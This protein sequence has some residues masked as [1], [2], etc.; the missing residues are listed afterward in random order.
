MLTPIR[1]KTS[2]ERGFLL[3]TKYYENQLQQQKR[4]E[5]SLLGKEVGLFIF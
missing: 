2:L 1:R 4:K 5:D 3:S